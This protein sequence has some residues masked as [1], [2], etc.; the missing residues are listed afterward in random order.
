MSS[1]DEELF[2]ILTVDPPAPLV[3]NWYAGAAPANIKR[4]YGVIRYYG[5]P[6]LTTQ[7]RQQASR[8]WRFEL[9][10]TDDQYLRGK[11]QMDLVVSFLALYTDSPAPGIQ[12]F[13]PLTQSSEFA[14]SQR[15]HQHHASFDVFENIP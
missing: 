3:P 5:S 7:D 13:L 15:F 12:R 2:S 9:T 14:E 1:I 4:P 6:Q 11:Q 10:I 8:Q